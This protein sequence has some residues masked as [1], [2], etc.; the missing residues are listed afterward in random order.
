MLTGYWLRP[1]L[2][3]YWLQPSDVHDIFVCVAVCQ[4]AGSTASVSG[5]EFLYESESTLH[6]EDSFL[7]QALGPSP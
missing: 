1:L 2:T 7:C 6:T 3:G 4:R 5:I